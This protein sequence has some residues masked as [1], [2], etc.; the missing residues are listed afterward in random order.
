MHFSWSIGARDVKSYR[1]FIESYEDHEFVRE[2]IAR[3]INHD[4]VRISKAIFWR[5]FVGCLLTS[6][7]QSGRHSRVADF[8][9]TEHELLDVEYC[10]NSRKLATQAS[11]VISKQGIRFGPQIG[12]YL[13]EAAEFLI[14][15]GWPQ[16]RSE[17]RSILTNTTVSKERRVAGFLQ[18]TFGGLGPKQSRN[19]IQWIG[20]SRFELPL[21]SRVMRVLE[22]LGFPV[23]LSSAALSDEKYY[24]FV[25][26]GIHILMQR[27]D[28]YPCV[29][30]ACAFASREQAV[31][32]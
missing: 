23:P 24:C 1:S 13:Q 20:L 28:R 6:Q 10:L 8:L 27:V 2:R 16:V 30:D 12:G 9:Q 17:L 3:N 26:D 32:E 21:D 5:T 15:K 29:F 14:N 18:R 22:D 25:E 11:D 19:L 31:L 7:Q 4:G